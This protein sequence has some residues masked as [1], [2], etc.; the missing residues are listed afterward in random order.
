MSGEDVDE[1]TKIV[2]IDSESVLPSDA[3][4][5]IY[6]SDV[7]ITI[8][9]TCFGTMVTGPRDSVEKVV[10]EVRALDPNHVFVK[11]RGFP[12]G[13][14]RRCRA[15][16]GGGPRPGFHYLRTEVASLPIISRALDEYETYNPSEK[17]ESPDKIS[18]SKLKDIIE[19]EL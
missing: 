6:E 17:E 4:M 11:Q 18:P 1:I 8:K 13:D 15:S 5:K 10:A 9:E 16:R 19:S 12:P 2:V 14:E 7:D 3:A